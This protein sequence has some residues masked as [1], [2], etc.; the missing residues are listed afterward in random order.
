MV[1]SDDL[2]TALGRVV[3][4]REESSSGGAAGEQVLSASPASLVEDVIAELSRTGQ[5]DASAIEGVPA[6]NA[7]TKLA[8]SPRAHPGVSAPSGAE[9]RASRRALWL[10]AV[11][12]V[13]AAA[14]LA[15]FVG[16]APT[17]DAS[18]SL[19]PYSAELR[20]GV[21]SVRSVQAARTDAVTLAPGTELTVLL[22]PDNPVSGQVSAV[23]G[24]SPAGTA[25]PTRVEARSQLAASGAL[26]VTFIVP[27]D[28]PSEGN[29]CAVVGRPEHV[30]AGLG[31]A[32]ESG[33]GWQRFC[34]PFMRIDAKQRK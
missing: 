22:R 1:D 26:R 13:A 25:T 20:G 6:A 9:T 15:L 7:T 11:P 29:V 19:A 12:S 30:E 10:W 4:E 34:W 14:A 2:L 23:I 18:A 8:E 21:A 33:Q 31:Q 27:S 24:L 5:K 32:V 28:L 16:R 3:R 17:E